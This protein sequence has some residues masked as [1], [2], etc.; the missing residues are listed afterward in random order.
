MLHRAAARQS[1]AHIRDGRGPDETH[2]LHREHVE[3]ERNETRSDASRKQQ[4]GRRRTRKQILDDAE[5]RVVRT[6]LCASDLIPT[7]ASGR[8]GDRM[9]DDRLVL[10]LPA[11]SIMRDLLSSRQKEH[12]DV[13][14]KRVESRCET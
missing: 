10:C 8:K 7:S 4:R 3:C 6:L 11:I 14:N 1:T 13:T 2:R 12:K 5:S 9:D